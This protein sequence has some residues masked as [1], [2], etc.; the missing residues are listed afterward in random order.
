M[1]KLIALLTA[2]LIAPSAMAHGYYGGYHGGYGEYH[3][4]YGGYH[5]GGGYAAPLIGGMVVGGVVGYALAHPTTTITAP[6]IVIYHDI[7]VGYHQELI[8]D[9]NC[10]CFRNVILP[11]Y[12]PWN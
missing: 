7:P 6:P 1:N 4:G 8:K 3:G 12:R 5:S 9:A 10:N 11:D 2:L